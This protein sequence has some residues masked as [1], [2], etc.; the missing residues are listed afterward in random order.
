MPERVTRRSLGFNW[1]AAGSSPVSELT[2]R[3]AS[4]WKGAHPPRSSVESEAHGVSGH[5]WHVGSV[6]LSASTR[7]SSCQT[8]PLYRREYLPHKTGRGPSLYSVCG[9]VLML[10]EGPTSRTDNLAFALCD[11]FKNPSARCG[12]GARGQWGGGGCHTASS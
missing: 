12:R 8:A 2:A 6:S 1:D 11:I 10:R 5:I 9:S 3:T 7:P 4:G